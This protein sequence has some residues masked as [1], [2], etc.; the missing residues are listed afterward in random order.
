MIH[1]FKV[2]FHSVPVLYFRSQ[3]WQE[4]KQSLSTQL[5]ASA[6][7]NQQL[8]SELNEVHSKCFALEVN[9]ADRAKMQ[10]SLLEQART[11]FCFCIPH[12]CAHTKLTETFDC[13]QRRLIVCEPMLLLPPV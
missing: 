3:T 6:T 12:A 5:N 7:H 2:I 11:G 1:F 8:E 10:E 13:K 4:E 9:L